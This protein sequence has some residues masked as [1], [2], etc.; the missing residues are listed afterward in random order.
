MKNKILQLKN[1]QNVYIGI[2]TFAAFIWLVNGLACKV[3]NLVPRHQAII[4]QILVIP[5]PRKVTIFLG[6][7]EIVMTIWILSNWRS[8]FN[9]IIQLVVIGTMNVL[10]FI[11]VPH[12]LLWGRL[13]IIFASL[14]M[15][16]IYCNEFKLKGQLQ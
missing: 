12:L 11:L 3:L 4:E 9:T 7:S 6:L 14:F 1:P 13:N 16:L 2:R 15:V 8:R 5:Q 10:E